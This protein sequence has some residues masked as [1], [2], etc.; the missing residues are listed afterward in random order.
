[1]KLGRLNHIHWRHD[2]WHPS[3]TPPIDVASGMAKIFDRLAHV[4]PKALPHRQ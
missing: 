4:L 3:T 2:A 1:M